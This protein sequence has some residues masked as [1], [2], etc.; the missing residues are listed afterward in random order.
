MR[1]LCFSSMSAMR[2]AWFSSPFPSIFLWHFTCFL[3]SCIHSPFHWPMS[4]APH[5]RTCSA[6]DS[7]QCEKG[8]HGNKHI[9]VSVSTVFVFRF[10]SSVGTVPCQGG[11]YWTYEKSAVQTGKEIVP[12]LEWKHTPWLQLPKWPGVYTLRHSSLWHCRSWRPWNRLTWLTLFCM[13]HLILVNCKCSQHYVQMPYAIL[14]WYLTCLP[15]LLLVHFLF[16]CLYVP[17]IYL[18]VL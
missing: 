18:L 11:L 13:L 15:S 17:F 4:S 14:M 7:W 2:A 10:I 9:H 1:L 12:R 8:K 16:R 6:G 5:Y 3:T